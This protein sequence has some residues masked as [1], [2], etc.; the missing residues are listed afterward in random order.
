[1]S[2]PQSKPSFGKSIEKPEKSLDKIALTVGT[3][4]HRENLI[5]L[6]Y[7]GLPQQTKAVASDP[8]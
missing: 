7:R 4:P 1:V 2:D 5:S 6:F 3:N 8:G